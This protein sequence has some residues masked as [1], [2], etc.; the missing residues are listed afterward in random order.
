MQYHV[1]CLVAKKILENL[2]REKSLKG[3]HRH[4]SKSLAKAKEE[5]I[6]KE[7]AKDRMKKSTNQTPNSMSRIFWQKVTTTKP[8]DNSQR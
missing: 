2:S 3:T 6:V 8:M 1:N 7:D 4:A 5:E